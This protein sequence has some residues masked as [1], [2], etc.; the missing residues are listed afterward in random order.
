MK[1]VLKQIIQEF[2]EKTL[3]KPLKRAFTLPEAAPPLRK[4]TVLVGM[5]RTGK[6]WALYQHMQD[7]L[8]TGLVKE[9]ILYINF[10]DERLFNFKTT[11][12]QL[13]LEAYFELY[14]QYYQNPNLFFYFDEIH[15]VPAW[16]KFIRR[17]LDQEN[18]Q[19]FVTGSSAKMLSKELATTLRGRE[20]TQ[21]VFPFSFSEYL[22]FNAIQRNAP[23]TTKT[24]SV[25]RHYADRYHKHGGFPESLFIEDHKLI[26]LLQSYVNTVVFRDIIERYS[27][28]NHHMV[29]L[30]LLHCLQCIAAPLSVNKVFN[31]FKSAGESLS[32]D[33]LYEYLSYFE[34]AFLIFA[35]PAYH[36]SL[37]IRQSTAKKIY[38]I[39]SSVIMAYSIKPHFEKGVCLENSVFMSLRRSC[40]TLFYYRTKTD[41]EID[42]LTLSAKGEITLYQVCLAF[43]ET[44]TKEREY[45]AILEATKELKL[46]EAW[47]IT[48]DTDEVIELQGIKIKTLP[49]WKWAK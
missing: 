22:E 32:K 33:K 21:E 35:I 39:D 17:L 8:A 9:K 2:H 30:F 47:I 44:S 18:M 43:N 31:S 28:T 38:T 3:P 36:H 40:N 19:I 45:A 7:K 12:C 1:T 6:T 4:A 11:D 49:Y 20:L 14:P 42:F 27:I 15:V 23:L 37:R 46:N 41:K 24:K 29:K 16:E 48:E 34:E 26:E 13:I 25:L 5:R 10:E